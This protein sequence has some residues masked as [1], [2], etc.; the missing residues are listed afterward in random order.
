MSCNPLNERQQLHQQRLDELWDYWL[1]FDSINKR[2]TYGSKRN[3]FDANKSYENMKWF[4]EQR[5]KLPFDPQSNITPQRLERAKREIKSFAKAL[6]GSFKNF[7]FMV[8]EGISKQDPVARKFYL[9]LNNILEYERVN[10]NRTG[11]LNSNIANNLLDAYAYEKGTKG[12]K[13]KTLLKLRELRQEMGDNPNEEVQAKFESEIENFIASDEGKIINEYIDLIH[14]PTIKDFKNKKSVSEFDRAVKRGY[15][16]SN[17]V[18]Q[19]YNPNVIKAVQNSQALLNDM[20]QVY[21]NGLGTLKQL[22]ALKYTNTK[23]VNLAKSTSKQARFFIENIEEGINNIKKGRDKGGYFPQISL[24][25]IIDVKEKLGALV[26]ANRNSVGF[27]SKTSDMLNNVLDGINQSLIP[28][29]AKMKNKSLQKYWE[30]DPLLVLKEYSEQATQFNKLI[31]TQT[32]YLDALRYIPKSDDNFV[33]GMKRFIDEEYAVF[34]KGTT[35]RPEWANQAATFFNAFQTATKMGFNVTGAVK[36]VASAVHFYSRIGFDMIGKTKKMMANNLDGIADII[37]RKEDEAGFLYNDVAKELYSEG[38]ITRNQYNNKTITFDPI[39]GKI[40]IDGVSFRDKALNL[41][42]KSID[43]LL[44]FHRLGENFQRQ[45]MFRSAFYK[46]YSDLTHHGMDKKKAEKFAGEFA[47]EMVNGWAYEYAAHAKSKAVRGEWRTV[48]EM[49]D[50]RISQRLKGVVGAGSEITFHLLHYPLSLI[51]GQWDT[52]K[53]GHKALLSKQFDSGELRYLTQYAGV[54]LATGLSSAL[55]NANLF[56]IFENDLY[57]RIKRSVDSATKYDDPDQA[58]FGVLSQFTGPT[59]G[60]MRYLANMANIIDMDNNKLN[61]I[62]LG[63]V[64]FTDEG[65]Q[66]VERYEAY[67]LSTFWGIAKN[68][69]IP[70]LETGRGRDLFM[71]FLKLYPSSWTKQGSEAIFGKHSKGKASK[72]NSNLDAS[73]AL[74]KSMSA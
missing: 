22:V 16:D 28:D 60:T 70:S 48:D 13:N 17:G 3:D 29:Q 4:V 1:T 39:T 64:D 40:K 66:D 10:L 30:K 11:T 55:F 54:M 32:E 46:K 38:L 18:K 20:G 61:K 73:L 65:N 14:K 72:I 34:T 58:T 26:N 43:K 41:A 7:A 12:R 2:F 52:I 44:T 63:N 5:L 24:D 25:T 35:G 15:V 9:K 49:G 68:K 19:A 62:L 36:N 53:G 51:E 37:E 59:I 74:I 23:D 21:L 47:L 69:I 71:H 50:M 31:N 56:N 42:G 8:P 45:W 57:E 6:N 67:Q 33:S 27:D